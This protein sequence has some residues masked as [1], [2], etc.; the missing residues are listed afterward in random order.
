MDA[1]HDL[2]VVADDFG[3]GPGTSRG[4]LDL[5]ALR[6]LEGTVLLVN[7][8]ITSDA[9]ARLRGRSA[10]RTRLTAAPAVV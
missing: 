2:I 1:A 10:R 4:I 7:S 3:I 6:R 9:V 8:P 5:A